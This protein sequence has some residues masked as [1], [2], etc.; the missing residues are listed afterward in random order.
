MFVTEGSCCIICMIGFELALFALEAV[1]ILITAYFS[2]A[3]KNVPGSLNEASN[4]LQG[5][6]FR[7]IISI[8]THN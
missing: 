3:T 2:Y 1:I 5:K 6:Y 7:N 8:C 4:N